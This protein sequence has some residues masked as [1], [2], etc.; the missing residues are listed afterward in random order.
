MI[1]IDRNL[2]SILMYRVKKR[3][4]FKKSCTGGRLRAHAVGPRLAC[5]P[6]NTPTDRACY[7]GVRDDSCAS[8]ILEREVSQ[9]RDIS[10]DSFIYIQSKHTPTA[11][12]TLDWL[13]AVFC[14]P[15][16]LM[17]TWVN[18][19]KSYYKTGQSTKITFK[20]LIWLAGANASTDVSQIVSCDLH[21]TSAK[22]CS[23][24][25]HSWLCWE[26]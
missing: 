7:T 14:N 13:S 19:R 6:L 1:V 17:I 16:S 21:K 26:S 15:R 22:K 2:R 12:A 25:T 4:S 5:R 24:L 20:D 23:E 11:T 8:Q 10:L 18:K 9:T 3:N